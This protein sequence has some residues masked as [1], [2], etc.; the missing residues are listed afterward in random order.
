MINRETI[1]CPH[2]GS[3]DIR[4]E[5][6]KALDNNRIYTNIKIACNSCDY[7]WKLPRVKQAVFYTNLKLGNEQQDSDVQGKM[8][9]IPDINAVNVSAFVTGILEV[10]IGI[11]VLG[12]LYFLLFTSP[13]VKSPDYAAIIIF[14]VCFIALILSGICLINI[15]RR[16]KKDI[17]KADAIAVKK[18]ASNIRGFVLAA[19]YV[20]DIF[21]TI[22][23][24]NEND[25][26]WI[27]LLVIGF[28]LLY[29]SLYNFYS[30]RRNYIIADSEYV[31]VARVFAAEKEYPVAQV[32]K[33]FRS[34]YGYEYMDKY[35]KVLFKVSGK[36]KNAEKLRQM[37]VYHNPEIQNVMTRD[38]S[39]EVICRRRGRKVSICGNKLTCT[40]IFGRSRVYDLN[41]LKNMAVYAN[42][43]IRLVFP[44]KKITIVSSYK[45]YDNFYRTFVKNL[46]LTKQMEYYN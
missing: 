40:N 25:I 24:R 42:N 10:I 8:A 23:C 9:S 35:N 6:Y 27:G 39:D 38:V 43:G 11:V 29:F 1:L 32:A 34:K 2:C 44:D 19:L 22:S 12:F 17:S 46:N 36:Y 18:D 37:I 20:A 26:S 13:V 31:S 7:K 14:S 4:V 3:D 41:D 16:H 21:Q 5:S 45:N 30:T 33:I 15:G 28:I